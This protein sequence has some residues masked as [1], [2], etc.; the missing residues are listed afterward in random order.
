MEAKVPFAGFYNTYHGLRVTDFL[1]WEYGCDNPDH[2]D[3]ECC[4]DTCCP[5]STYE[6]NVH[7]S[8]AYCKKFCEKLTELVGFDIAFKRMW[9]PKYYNFATDEI[10]AEVSPEAV[11]MMRDQVDPERMRRF[12]KNNFTSEPGFSSFYDNDYDKWGKKLEV[13][14]RDADG[15]PNDVTVSDQPFDAIQIWA[16]LK[17]YAV[18]KAEEK[19]WADAQDWERYLAETIEL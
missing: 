11:E 18:M 3:G 8:E 13:H 16:L 19:K 14:E 2:K 7:A 4:A 6:Q 17:V 9:S 12:V 1:L 10:Y 5:R 15:T